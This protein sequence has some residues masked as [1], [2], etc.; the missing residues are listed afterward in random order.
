MAEYRL[1]ERARSD[2]LAIYDYTDQSFGTYQAEAYFAGLI[3]TFAL[4]AEFPG[5]GRSAD[6]ILAHYRRFSFQSHI[7]Y[8][9]ADDGLVLIN[10]IIHKGQDIRPGLF[11]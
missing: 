10:A 2:L 1:S 7:I 4:L 11:E 6:E 8:Y 9:T 5:I 3:K